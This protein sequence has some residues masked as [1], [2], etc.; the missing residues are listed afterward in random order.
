MLVVFTERHEDTIR[1]LSAR[2]ASTT[3]RTLYVEH[4]KRN[5]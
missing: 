5:T 2:W 1:I 3:E 4:I